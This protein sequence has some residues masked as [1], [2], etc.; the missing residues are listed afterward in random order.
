MS[1]IEMR[2]LSMETAVAI[3]YDYR[4]MAKKYRE[5]AEE[6]A[7][8]ARDFAEPLAK[9]VHSDAAEGMKML[10][11]QFE[12]LAERMQALLPPEH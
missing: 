10:A 7:Q 12:D 4:T 2:R 8:W 1:E 11:Q 6:N 9:Q 3:L 5:Q